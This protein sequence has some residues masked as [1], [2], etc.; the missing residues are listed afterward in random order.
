MG[1]LECAASTATQS[2]FQ[3]QNMKLCTFFGIEVFLAD[4][5]IHSAFIECHELEIIEQ[6]YFQ[7]YVTQSKDKEEIFVP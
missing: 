3:E 4:I 7:Y 6:K 5:Y 2:D 1:W